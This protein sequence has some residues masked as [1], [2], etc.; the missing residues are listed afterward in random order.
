MKKTIT[1]GL[2]ILG[3]KLNSQITGSLGARIEK[4]GYRTTATLGYNF[5]NA[6]TKIFYNTNKFYGIEGAYT[7]TGYDFPIGVALGVQCGVYDGRFGIG[8]PYL[9]QI[10]KIKKISP[11]LLL[12]PKFAEVRIN[13]SL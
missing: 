11:S 12:S 6:S 4:E 13:I 1:L 2:V 3:L 5:K 10:F 9:E 7:P 8:Y